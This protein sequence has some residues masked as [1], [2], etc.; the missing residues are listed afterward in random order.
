[1]TTPDPPSPVATAPGAPQGL[2]A[3][4]GNGSV[5]LTWS[6]GPDGGSRILG[7]TLTCEPACGGRTS[8]DVNP[9]ETTTVEGLTNGTSY[10][11][12]LKAR[13]AVNEGPAASAGPV[14]PTANVPPTPTNVSATANDDGTVSISWRAEAG[15]LTLSRFLIAATS[16]GKA[17]QSFTTNGPGTTFRTAPD[18]LAYVEEGAP[19][20]S[21]TVQA[22]AGDKTGD[23]S[24]PSAAVAPFNTPV[25]TGPLNA[26]ANDRTAV[27]S[28][29][30]ANARGRS[31]T[32]QV[33]QCA[34]AGCTPGTAA[35]GAPNAAGNNMTMSVGGLVYGTT[36]RFSVQATNAAGRSATVTSQNVVPVG[37]PTVQ[38]GSVTSTSNSITATFT[39]TWAGTPGSCNSTGQGAG[40]IDC[41]K[42]LVIGSLTASHAYSFAVCATNGQGQSRCSAT[43]T[44]STKAPP[45]PP[46]IAKRTDP[47]G[48]TDEAYKNTNGSGQHPTHIQPGT[49]L[50]VECR[51]EDRTVSYNPGYNWYYIVG[52]TWNGYWV[53]ASVFEGPDVDTSVPV[54]PA[55][56]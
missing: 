39:V 43:Q 7:Y 54:C 17:R 13:N 53:P 30:K 52:G 23:S 47:T 36:Y 15:G 19:G 25:L 26:Q 56:K 35:A 27:L 6:T 32:Y 14:T 45:P 18:A 22:V 12:T 55:G 42:P 44:F 2:A 24:A 11:F 37:Q 29:P 3:T 38:I 21:F 31:V 8:L 49:T 46:T 28:W 33:L 48:A 4:G 20:W 34:G 9:G 51:K 41:G 5:T 10:R 40:A 1:V 16:P 50:Q